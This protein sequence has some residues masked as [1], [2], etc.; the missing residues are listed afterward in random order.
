MT[1]FDPGDAAVQTL[2][3]VM[4]E[5]THDDERRDRLLD[6]ILTIPPLTQWPPDHRRKLWETCEFLKALSRD[7][8]QRTETHDDSG[9]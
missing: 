5:N 1:S 6:Y 2:L 8:R 4:A 3:A 7:F 9:D